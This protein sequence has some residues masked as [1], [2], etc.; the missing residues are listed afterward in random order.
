MKHTL[1]RTILCTA[2]SQLII[3]PAN[4]QS[5][6]FR[7][8]TLNLHFGTNEQPEEI[9]MSFL[10]NYKYVT[11]KCPDDGYYTYATQ[12]SGCFNND[13]HTLT[14]DH[15][16]NDVNGKFL[17]V[18]AA[19]RPGPF[20]ICYPGKLKPN[21]KYEFS[22]WLMNICRTNSGCPPL[23]PDINISIE[24]EDGRKI[25]EFNT[26]SLTRTATP[27]WALY[28]GMFSTGANTDRMMLIMNDKNRGGCGNDFALDDIMIRECYP[29]E[30]KK[31][32]PPP[33][34]KRTAPV[35]QQA[36]VLPDPEKSLNKKQ[37][38]PA[39]VSSIPP[40]GNPKTPAGINE[41]NWETKTPL[42]ILNRANPVISQIKT[43]ATILQVALYDNGQIDGDTVSIYHNNKLVAEKVG[44]SASPIRLSINV[45]K[46]EPHHELIMVAEN[47]GSI[48]PNTSLMI[49]TGAGKRQ[50]IFISSSEESNARILI[51]LSE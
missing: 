20:F 1:L 50:E 15:T 31:S 14:E 18:N 46:S 25:A 35:T 43:K 51:D 3:L 12:T 4:A 32:A 38:N 45:S 17:L 16:H 27:H 19:E 23:S 10:P 22:V 5:C 44:L 29:I 48:P 34:E 37:I 41:R 8:T 39:P 33:V 26:G 28:N 7:D 36:P 21:T 49:V 13:W 30:E 42:P 6:E 2:L 9:R 24:S 40:S 11:G 47:L